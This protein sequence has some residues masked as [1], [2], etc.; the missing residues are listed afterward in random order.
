LE[1][2]INFLEKNDIYI[3]LVIVLIVWIGIFL[4]LWNMDKRIKFVE[5]EIN[6]AV[7]D[8]K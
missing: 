8:E 3:V 6:G 4:Y 7:K 2:L 1:S 5:K